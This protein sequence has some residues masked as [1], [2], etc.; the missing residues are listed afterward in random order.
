MR[1]APAW[2]LMLRR[3]LAAIACDLSLPAFERAVTEGTLPEPVLLGGEPRWSLRA[4]E[5]ALGILT[6]EDAPDWRARQREINSH[7]A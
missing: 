5:A 2:P 3:D 4:I 7:A 6:G 1:K